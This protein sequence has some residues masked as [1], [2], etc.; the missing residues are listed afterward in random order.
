MSRDDSDEKVVEQQLLIKLLCRGLSRL[1]VAAHG[2]DPRLDVLLADLR[3]LL[4][5]EL[6][7]ATELQTLIDAI[8]AR[9]K[10]VDDSRNRH[11]DKLEE[12]L[13]RLV[14]QL[15]ALRPPRDIAAD[16]KALKKKIGAT[17]DDSVVP[18][19]LAYAG[20]QSQVLSV[21]AGKPGLLSRLFGG[22]AAG[23][24]PATVADDADTEEPLPQSS[25]AKESAPA[26][27]AVESR[28]TAI[29]T[30]AL[31]SSAPSHTLSTPATSA[32]AL[33]GEPVAAEGAAD[34][35]GE[36]AFSRVSA[37]VC[38]VINQLMRQIPPPPQAAENHAAVLQR[39][40]GGLNWYELVPTL[41]D[42]S[43]VVLAA[44]E[45][46]RGD[47]LQYLLQ[48]NQRLATATQ[49]L[50]ASK[51]HQNERRS[52]DAELNQTVR[53]NIEAMQL[54]VAAA[55][56]LD[57]LK[58]EVTTR[59]ESVVLAMD[60]HQAAE[61][62]RQRD[63]EQYLT[64]LEER[65]QQ[66]EQQS[67]AMEQQMA[68]QRR[69]ALVDVLTQLPNRSAYDERATYEFERWTR[70]KRSLVLAV[71]D[72]DRFKSINDNFGHLAG[73]K[74]LR[75][76]ARTLRARLRKTDFVA[77]YG[78]EEFVVLMPEAT[79]PDAL[80][81]LEMVRGAVAECPF[82]FRDQPLKITLSAGLAQF[83]EGDDMVTVFERADRALYT[84]KENGRDRCVIAPDR[85]QPKAQGQN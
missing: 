12:A 39:V 30:P 36:P 58:S 57:T 9:I 28:M 82:H 44:L 40:S 18:F 52:A 41:E 48:L 77:R 50:Q 63:M 64:V 43:Y 70:Y 56:S 81:A 37:A 53:G 20:L 46:D 49:V 76:L 35:D 1:A 25:R 75:I 59:L 72:V 32:P 23:A 22:D 79:L 15:L 71:C 21:P 54:K 78:G 85:A 47:F 67:T 69:L 13:E 11:G 68:E 31:A 29:S 38:A 60:V 65:I 27:V 34:S 61:V 33:V 51:E 8:D 3:K 24:S 19:L 73:D 45:R 55:T 83:E 6:T 42:L 16:L 5:S 26:L 7:D 14:S 2:I 80:A 74:V 66:M 62:G 4:R 10:D 17:S 84:A